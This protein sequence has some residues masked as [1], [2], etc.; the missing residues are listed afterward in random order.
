MSRY[1]LAGESNKVEESKRNMSTYV[2]I[3]IKPLVESKTRLAPFFNQEERSSFVK[4]LMRDLASELSQSKY[5]KQTIICTRDP[6]VRSLAATLG[7]HC[8]S[9]SKKARELEDFIDQLISVALVNGAKIAVNTSIDLPLF[10]AS[11]L[12]KM[13]EMSEPRCVVFTIWREGGVSTLLRRPPDVVRTPC[14]CDQPE[15]L[16]LLRA[17]HSNIR[18]KFCDSF[19]LSFDVDYPRDLI[20]C[21]AFLSILKSH[22]RTFKFVR[23]YIT[24]VRKRNTDSLLFSPG[25][26]FIRKLGLVDIERTTYTV[27]TS[28]STVS[29][30]TANLRRTKIFRN[31]VL[32]D[33]KRHFVID[34]HH[35]VEA[36]RALGCQRI[37]VQ[38]VDYE[39]PLIKAKKWIRAIS[40][41]KRPRQ[42]EE[43]LVGNGLEFEEVSEPVSMDKY[44]HIL[45][46]DRIL[47]VL[48]KTEDA[49]QRM[50]TMAR[51][52]QS[53]ML[54]GLLVRF[55]T[56]L[57]GQ[58]KLTRGECD[59]LLVPFSVSKQ[60]TLE[61]ALSD[62]PFA[63][64]ENR[65][66]V[67]GRI[68]HTDIPLGLLNI[69]IAYDEAL[70]KLRRNLSK[71]CVSYHEP[72]KWVDYRRYEEDIFVFED[73]L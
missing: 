69:Q 15:L 60:L 56:D 23:R 24:E 14:K 62:K 18:Y 40:Q 3:P 36:A 50:Q 19:A 29:E 55:E 17:A 48:E 44:T 61:A 68:L 9:E 5:V 57:D 47:R 58:L 10:S 46:H 27:V 12:D 49:W 51:L 63:T 33:Q 22:S 59:A 28:Q 73:S 6:K 54:N 7:F 70:R 16:A 43:I 72:G 39:D 31:P 20:Q 64:T 8:I 1:G 41:I 67:P 37:P 52:E 65:S 71:R 2:L 35:R 38:F 4:A 21:F 30:L 53:M 66:V 13:I 34:G 45:Y 32:F 42:L 25:R 26:S 11:A